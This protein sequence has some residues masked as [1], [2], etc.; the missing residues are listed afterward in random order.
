M[1]KTIFTT[2]SLLLIATFTTFAKDIES[3]D[4]IR[5]RIENQS[6]IPLSAEND[7][8][9]CAESLSKIYQ[10]RMFT[11]AWKNKNSIAQLIQCINESQYEG[12]N[13]SDYH[14]E[15]LLALYNNYSTLNADQKANIDLL[16]T[17][18]FLLYTTHL[19][20]G[21]VN[22]TTIDPEWQV[23]R[24]EGNPV[25][26]FEKAIQ[27]NSITHYIQ[28]SLPKHKTY[29]GLKKALLIYEKIK[30][31]GGWT[32]IQSDV[33]LKKGDENDQIVLIK[34]RLLATQ[35]LQANAIGNIRQFDDLL[36]DAVIHF[37]I[38]HNLQADGNV[39]KTTISAMNISVDDRIDQIKVNMER[40][41]WLPQEFSNYYVQV[42]IANFSVD[43]YKDGQLKRQH[44]AIVGKNYRR[45]PVFSSKIS[46][47]VL[48]P[49]WTV[50][51]GIINGDVIPGVKK[52]LSYLKKKNLTVLDNK[53]IVLD[54]NKVDWNSS[55]VKSYT[56]RQ[57]AGPDNSLGAVKFMFPNQY[58]VYLHDTPHR[59]LFEQTERSFS[60]GCIRVQNPLL[61]AEFFLNDST[62]WNAGKIQKQVQSNETLTIPLKEQPDIYILYW[63]TWTNDEGVIQFRNDLYNRDNAVKI[64]LKEE[65]KL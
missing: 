3:Q 1:K 51:P 45:T 43:V 33:T 31:D 8:I 15:I 38:R 61:L 44:K 13:P 24:R 14:L 28:E 9:Y 12:L 29:L 16:A 35:D 22:P 41:R 4:I 18:A 58:N 48:N 39:G 64:A 30:E 34:K 21:K 63:T 49:T 47:L 46:Y 25:L 60:S 5:K 57:P 42:N 23:K 37:Q 56:Y 26:L 2:I 19:L 10:D 20:S 54:P 53:G 32:E 65:K 6:F 55:I 36:N 62:N 52:D 7:L 27:E 40:W 50:P 11:L 59:D 17:D